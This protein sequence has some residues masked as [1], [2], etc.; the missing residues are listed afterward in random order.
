M[1]KFLILILFGIIPILSCTDITRKSTISG[2]VTGADGN[3]PP[4]AHVH[5]IKLGD[6]PSQALKFE[7]LHPDGSFNLELEKGQYYEL[8]FT[9]VNHTP[10]KIPL[11]I[12]KKNQ[13]IK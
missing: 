1:R 2:T 4:I 13:T 9:A 12:N 8:L 6:N 3:V 7:P 5:L 11:L 10:V